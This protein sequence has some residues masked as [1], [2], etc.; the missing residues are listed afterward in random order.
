ML[1]R[2][3]YLHRS[4][5]TPE[6][7]ET[8]QITIDG[9]EFRKRLMM[10]T[11]AEKGRGGNRRKRHSHSIIRPYCTSTTGTGTSGIV[12]YDADC[13]VNTVNQIIVSLQLY[14]CFACYYRSSAP[15]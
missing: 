7:F 1:A 8:K 3:S 10:A 6:E 5:K 4:T 15:Q 11:D 2:N 12:V 14:N 9:S 13:A